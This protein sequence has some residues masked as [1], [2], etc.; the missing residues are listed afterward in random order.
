MLDFKNYYYIYNVAIGASKDQ[1]VNQ[2][3]F[4]QL[5]QIEF[6]YSDYISQYCHYITLFSAFIY[7][8]QTSETIK[9]KSEWMD[10]GRCETQRVKD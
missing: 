5:R 6:F 1:S 2:S 4:S 3:T 7:C 9:E 10:R 8:H